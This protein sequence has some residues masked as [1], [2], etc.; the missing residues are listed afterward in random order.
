MIYTNMR[1]MLQMQLALYIPSNLLYI[2]ILMS[3]NDFFSYATFLSISESINE[4]LICKRI[5]IC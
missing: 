1:N 3:I 2:Y 4:K 5:H